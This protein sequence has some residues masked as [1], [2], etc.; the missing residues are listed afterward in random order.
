MTEITIAKKPSKVPGDCASLDFP[1]GRRGLLRV[2]VLP[3]QLATVADSGRARRSGLGHRTGRRRGCPRVCR[4]TL[5]LYA[6]LL[7]GTRT[8]HP[9]RADGAPASCSPCDALPPLD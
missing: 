7:P 1:R 9:A 4:L 6:R 5:S 2:D 8:A 3:Q